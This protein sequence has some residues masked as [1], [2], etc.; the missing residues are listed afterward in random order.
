M[1]QD[2]CANLLGMPGDD[3]V[4]VGVL[5]TK[6]PAIPPLESASEYSWIDSSTGTGGALR[7]RHRDDRRALDRDLRVIL[8]DDH[9]VAFW[10]TAD[11]RRLGWLRAAS[12]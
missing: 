10:L 9:T 8:L 5:R 1:T 4:L 11:G 3:D 6:I 7:I 2:D 12:A